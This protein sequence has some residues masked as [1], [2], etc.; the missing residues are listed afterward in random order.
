MPTLP[1]R[2]YAEIAGALILIGAAF[3]FIHHERQIGA[4]K[5][6]A[7]DAAAELKEQQHVDKVNA[8]ATAT[9]QDLQA[10]F[11]ATLAAPPKPSIVVRVCP[12]TPFAVQV[13]PRDAPPVAGSD[14]PPRPSGGVGGGNAE[15]GIDIA[16]PTE[17][18]LKRDKAIMD[19]FRG[20]VHECQRIGNCAK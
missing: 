4:D 9:I 16:P 11:A 19:Y 17:A 18:I 7:R 15:P 12:T 2:L 1:L 14:G 6:L 8:D 3:W 13:A 20:Y 5:I 10:R